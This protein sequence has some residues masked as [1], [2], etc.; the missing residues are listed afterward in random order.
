MI[1]FTSELTLECMIERIGEWEKITEIKKFNDFTSKRKDNN[2]N[3]N[4]NNI[5]CFKCE[6]FGHYANKCNINKIEKNKNLNMCNADDEYD[7]K[8]DKI[9]INNSEY[10]AIFDSGSS[11][12]L[13]SFN[14]V[15]KL[16]LTPENLK[17]NKTIKLVDGRKIVLTSKVNFDVEYK[18]NLLNLEFLILKNAIAN[19][20]I[21]SKSIEDLN[22][23]G[24]FPIECPIVTKGETIISWSRPIRN[25][26]KK[27]ILQKLT[28]ELEKEGVVEPS[29]SL[30]CHPVV[31]V[32]K[33]DGKHRF[34][35]DLTRLNDLVTL[36]EF[37]IPK[38]QEIIHSLHDAKYFSVVDLK[39]GFFQVPIRQQ[40][41]EKIAY[42]DANNRLMQ[43]RKMPQGFKNSPAIFQRGIYLILK[44]FIGNKCFVYIDDIL[45]FG[46]TEEEHDENLNDVLKRLK[47][48]NLKIN[49]EK[50]KFK[51]YEVKFL[52]YNISLNKIKPLLDRS[53]GIKNFPTPKN[54]RDLRKFIGMINY[55]RI[56]I[57]NLSERLKPFYEILEM[58]SFKWNDEFSK[59][60][61]NIK[62]KWCE[63]LTLYIP[64][65]NKRYCLETDASEIGLGGVLKQEGRPIAY[66]SRL[67]KGS[68]KNYSITEKEFL[69]ILWAMEKFQYLLLGKEFDLITDHKAIEKVKKNREFGT[70][71]IQRWLERIQN[72]QFAI[73]YSPGKEMIRADTLS[74]YIDSK[75]NGVI[76]FMIDNDKINKIL[77]M[78][79]ELG[80][81]KN[82]FH[83]VSK[84]GIIISKNK[85]R[86]IING[87]ERCRKFDNKRTQSYTFIKTYEAGELVACDIL[88]ITK[89]TLII[90]LIDYFTR[91]VFSKLIKS[92][93]PNEIVKILDETYS[94]FK[95]KRLLTDNGK[96]FSNIKVN[97]WCKEHDVIHSFSIPYYH[98]SNDRVE[99]VN[100]TIRNALKRTKGKI[101]DN[102]K[103]L[104]NSYNS[105]YH[106]GIECLQTLQWIL[107][108]GRKS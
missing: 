6:K 91:K 40:D 77:K 21:G 49:K 102:L 3:K 34:T 93:N 104:I 41:K 66:V 60:F 87:C 65:P 26:L 75:R 48:F 19:I 57:P 101:K 61:D 70:P 25:P 103:T 80:H 107:R 42:L 84:Q 72:F 105:S 54:K 22:N 29:K 59:L 81:R 100:G 108:I 46:K 89:K 7:V 32:E 95:F 94:K 9:K 52:G 23:S 11:V 24:L 36:D 17:K 37:E 20:I 78:H 55:D 56:F 86:K 1:F 83:E 15:K 92:K 16:N 74:R 44:E 45:I 28:D 76:N 85:L 33:K 35:L 73:R 90:N 8:K 39:D 38:I 53:E 97:K 10:V 31:V 99:R 71:R 64:D 4:A 79:T 30:W 63:S 2:K 62:N 58:N 14:F 82:I 67:L 18:G 27:K 98:T 43:F 88:E 5:K 13:V 69:A 12:N 51:Q 106:R 47:S 96:E 68:E 50:S